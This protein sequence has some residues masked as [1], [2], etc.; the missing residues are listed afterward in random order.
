MVGWVA[1]GVITINQTKDYSQATCF[2][3]FFLTDAKL[4]WGPQ[5]S[6]PYIGNEARSD[7]KI[8]NHWMVWSIQWSLTLKMLFVIINVQK[9]KRR[10]LS[11]LE[12]LMLLVTAILAS[13]QFSVVSVFVPKTNTDA[14]VIYNSAGFQSD[15]ELVPISDRNSNY[16]TIELF[17]PQLRVWQWVY[18]QISCHVVYVNRIDK[19]TRYNV[20]QYIIFSGLNFGDPGVHLFSV[21]IICLGHCLS[22]FRQ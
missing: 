11:L 21:N 14:N 1:H 6:I 17:R 15:K 12:S 2:Q 5:W 3:G 19:E 9:G 4:F 18:K 7:V 16:I 8:G 20:L 10:N 22:T 13:W